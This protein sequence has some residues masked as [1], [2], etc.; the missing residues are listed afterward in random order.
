MPRGDLVVCS[1]HTADPYYTGFADALR[2]GL[3]AQGIPHDVHRLVKGPDD[4][5]AD[6]T[7]RKVGI[8]DAACR[9]HPDKKVF[10]IDVDCSLVDL[11]DLVADFSADVIG[12]QRGF[13]DPL[14]IGYGRRTRFWEPCFFGINTTPSA[15]DFVATAA[16]L[17]RSSSLKATDDYFFEEAWRTRAAGMSFQV[18]PSA[19][20]VGRG[21]DLPGVPQFFRFGSSGN[22]AEYRDKV[23][24]HEPVG[25]GARPGPRERVTTLAHRTAKAVHHRLPAGA[26][27]QARDAADRLGI[28]HLLTA[29]DPVAGLPSGGD[30]TAV[31]RRAAVRT[32]V[33]A[34][35]RGD[36]ARVE[37]GMA[38]VEAA[39]GP[40]AAERAAH[41]AATAYAHYLA[42]GDGR[43]PLPLSWWSRPFPGNFGD[44]LSPYLLQALSGRAVAYKAP[45]AR[46]SSPHLVAVGSIGRFVSASSVVVGTGVSESDTWLDPA[47]R[48]V[49][50]RGPVT[51][52]ALRASGGPDVER[53]GD[54]GALLRRVLPLERGATNG[55]V[56]LVR[57]VRHRD[58]P[59]ILP[60]GTDELSVLA[61]TPGQVEDLVRTLVSYDRVVTSAMHVLVACQSYGIPCA[62]VTFAGAEDAVHGTGV[63]YGDYVR[64]V[65]LGMS[66]TPAVVGLDL[67]RLDLDPLTTDDRV[68]DRTL[69]DV[70]DAVRT[71]ADLV[72]TPAGV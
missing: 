22:V 6:M 17:E 67:R 68:D 9:A 45:T 40:S 14:S 15:R 64:G 11:P 66:L 59:T 3:D 19:A 41:E 2:A 56:A 62:L 34:G 43:E 21:A 27:R 61:G 12:F 42:V 63:K 26:R 39:G 50:V 48:Y 25:S 36:L 4:D 70:E 30:A 65:G 7:R 37:A 58:L 46:T 29:S 53:F 31:A 35:Q 57:H 20:V 44:W 55:R 60:E 16:A 8:L 51:A 47:A 32:M 49:S 13:A 72:L 23:V 28:T 18:I 71:A 69:D 52:A 10:W 54:P 33:S 38:A 5:W 1:F 24:Q